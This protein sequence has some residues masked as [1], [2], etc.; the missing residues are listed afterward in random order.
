MCMCRIHSDDNIYSQPALTDLLRVVQVALVV[1]VVQ[2]VQ[3]ALVALAM[4]DAMCSRH[5]MLRNCLLT[6]ID[7]DE[8]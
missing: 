8:R 7:G 4:L 2:V 1:Q 6:V 5:E 3:V